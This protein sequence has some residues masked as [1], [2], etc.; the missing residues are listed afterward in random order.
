MKIPLD[1]FQKGKG[2]VESDKLF[3]ETLEAI[4][5]AIYLDLKK[6]ETKNVKLK[7]IIK[8]WF[9]KDLNSIKK[10]HQKN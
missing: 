5:A 3:A 4:V 6:N 7:K 2:E 9:K 10:S 8:K 1:Y